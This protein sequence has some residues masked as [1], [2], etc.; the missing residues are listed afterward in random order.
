MPE[1]LAVDKMKT[2]RNRV[3]FAH[4][5]V[6][7]AAG[8]FA[9]L[10]HQVAVLDDQRMAY[11]LFPFGEHQDFAQIDILHGS[12]EDEFP[13]FDGDGIP[14]GPLSGFHTFR[15]AIKARADGLK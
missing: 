6:I 10:Q 2:R 11:R 5:T 14:D 15:A 3:H 1:R 8:E 9:V 7:G 12:L 13:V 4:E